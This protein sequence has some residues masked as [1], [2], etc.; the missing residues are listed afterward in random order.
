[1]AEVSATQTT[2]LERWD[3]WTLAALAWVWTSYATEGQPVAQAAVLR[4]FQQQYN[5][6]L[7]TLQAL[8][9]RLRITPLFPLRRLSTSG[10]YN[11][12]T[13][14]AMS[15]ASDFAI[16]ARTWMAALPVRYDDNIVAMIWDEIQREFPTGTTRPAPQMMW[17]MM[18]NL[19]GVAPEQAGQVA[20]NTAA[21]LASGANDRTAYQMT[22]AQFAEQ[23]SSK[24]PG[25]GGQNLPGKGED[26]QFL[27]APE[28]GVDRSYAFD[29]DVVH[30]RR[31][32]TTNSY[33]IWLVLAGALGVGAIAYS[34]YRSEA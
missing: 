10:T 9:T 17:A 14:R 33:V 20:V 2:A 7:G 29:P 13:A 32:A 3:V 34:R 27:V 11:T 16:G 4:T 19:I 25:G 15:N 23:L 30:G 22:P 1:M 6:R 28:E 5:A 18:R 24:V 8:A 21:R 12:D 26:A 31:Q